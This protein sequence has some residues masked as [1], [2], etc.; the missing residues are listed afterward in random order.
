MRKTLESL[1]AR[2]EIKNRALTTNDPP[3]TILREVLLNQSEV[4]LANLSGKQ[5]FRKF[6]SRAHNGKASWHKFYWE[7]S[8]K[9]AKIDF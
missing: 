8:G 5:A 4:R 3:G 7:D 2:E 1:K 9:S 6:I